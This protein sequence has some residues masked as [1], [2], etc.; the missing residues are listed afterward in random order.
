MQYVAFLLPIVRLADGAFQS[1]LA[2][3]KERFI[4][5]NSDLESKVASLQRSLDEAQISLERQQEDLE[6]RLEKE[7]DKH[8]SQLVNSRAQ[9]THAEQE[10]VRA[11]VETTKWR[12]Q[13]SLAQ[14]QL[15]D[16]TKL[17]EVAEESASTRYAEMESMSARVDALTQAKG[18]LEARSQTLSE[19]YHN[20]D[21]TDIEKSFARIIEEVTE[22]SYKNKILEK[23]NDLKR[24]QHL[25][26][27]LIICLLLIFF[28]VSRWVT[29]YPIWNRKLHFWKRVL[30]AV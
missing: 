11:S 22:T 24:V 30:L 13:L 6:A 16:I 18:E 17:K 2:S 29:R 5:V 7:R 14:I 19:R 1:E 25:G 21:L 8:Q 9:A 23:Q 10:L 4:R 20:G 15:A 27:L 12:E 28:R 3:E 26:D